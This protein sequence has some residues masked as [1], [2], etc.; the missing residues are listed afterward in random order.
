MQPTETRLDQGGTAWPFARIPP[1]PRVSLGF[2]IL[3]LVV[4]KSAVAFFQLLAFRA[5]D[6]WFPPMTWL[7]HATGG[8]VDGTLVAGV[9]LLAVVVVGLLF[10]VARLGPRDVGLDRRRLRPALGFLIAAWAAIQLLLVLILPLFGQRI[11]LG[12]QWTADG[13]RSAVGQW[14][15]QLLGNCPYEELFFRGFLLPQSGL[16]AMRW[17]P[18]AR[19][20]TLVA[21]ALVLSQG[22]FALGHVFLNLHLPEG[23]WLLVAQFVFGI[24]FALVYLRT[25]NLFLAMAL[26]ALLNNPAPLLEDRLPGPGYVGS[27]VLVGILAWLSSLTWSRRHAG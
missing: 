12:P 1:P 23:Q 24:V 18:S 11:G 27:I 3:A 8:I 22:L 20:R 19:P 21:A 15:G 13:W 17:M 2:L 26:H 14:L 10:G 5:P 25:G 4:E 16:L 6:R 9:T 7:G